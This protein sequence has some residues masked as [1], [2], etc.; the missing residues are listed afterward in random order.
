MVG[1]ENAPEDLSPHEPQ[2][3]VRVWD[4]GYRAS[5]VGGLGYLGLG[6]RIRI[7]GFRGWEVGVLG[8]GV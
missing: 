1:R 4:S 6:F 2:T 7:K 8:F 5:E 3:S